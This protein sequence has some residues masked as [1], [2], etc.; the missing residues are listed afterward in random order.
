MRL[1][2]RMNGDFKKVRRSE[3]DHG[4]QFLAAKF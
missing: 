1:A 4:N 2:E 3:R